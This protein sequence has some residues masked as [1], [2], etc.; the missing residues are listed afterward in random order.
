MHTPLLEKKDSKNPALAT[1]RLFTDSDVSRF[2]AET[3]PCSGLERDD[4]KK[5]ISE[6]IKS[7]KDFKAVF[8][9]ERKIGKGKFG[10]VFYCSR[11]EPVAGGINTCA[12]KAISLLGLNALALS[13]LD[14]EIKTLRLLAEHKAKYSVRYIHSW[15]QR[16]AAFIMTEFVKGQT[17]YEFI[18][19]GTS[20]LPMEKVRHYCA[21]FI[22]ALKEL[23]SIGIAYRDFKPENVIIDTESETIKL[24]DLG[25]ATFVPEDGKLSVFC[26]SPHYAAPEIIKG[27]SYNFAP[28]IW[29]LAATMFSF[30]AQQMFLFEDASESLSWIRKATDGD[31]A[32]RLLDYYFQLVAFFPL[33]TRPI[34]TRFSK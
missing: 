24:V 4:K 12:L 11:R 22:A 19:Q 9:K 28:D 8:T 20:Y 31:I 26:G 25:F 16:D 18:T 30:V 10:E 1:G 3:P 29:S 32:G 14:D 27:Q 5:P 34:Y 15:K 7:Y 23:E 6:E 33:R 21:Q 2:L 17:L 13:Q